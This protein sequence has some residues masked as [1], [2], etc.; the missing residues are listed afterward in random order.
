MKEDSLR[1]D[2]KERPLPPIE[3]CLCLLRFS[4]VLSVWLDPVSEAQIRLERRD[5]ASSR[6][7]GVKASPPRPARLRP[8]AVHGSESGLAAL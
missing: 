2:E 1:D 3:P 8:P 6:A 7:E 5:E 4:F